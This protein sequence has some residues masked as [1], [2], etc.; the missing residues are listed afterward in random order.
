MRRWKNR[1]NFRKY[2]RCMEW[3]RCYIDWEFGYH[4]KYRR[5]R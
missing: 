5:R 1:D 4:R 2:V 3:Q